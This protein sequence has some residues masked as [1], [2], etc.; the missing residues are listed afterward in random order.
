MAKTYLFLMIL[1]AF[2]FSVEAFKCPNVDEVVELCTSEIKSMNKDEFPITEPMRVLCAKGKDMSLEI[3]KYGVAQRK[4]FTQLTNDEEIL[5]CYSDF[6]KEQGSILSAAEKPLFSLHAR[7]NVKN[8]LKMPVDLKKLQPLCSELSYVLKRI[9]G[10]S[11]NASH[12]CDMLLMKE[13]DLSK[14]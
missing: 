4:S 8:R 5:L 9:K 7:L 3:Y 11:Q 6:I 12:E 2:S 1:Y 10:Y 13:E 14:D